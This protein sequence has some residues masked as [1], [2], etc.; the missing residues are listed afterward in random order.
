MGGETHDQLSKA[1]HPPLEGGVLARRTFL[2]GPSL[3]FSKCH[4]GLRQD[5]PDQ[6]PVITEDHLKDS[7]LGAT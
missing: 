7:V 1:G 6:P 5:A 4:T 2:W 3:G